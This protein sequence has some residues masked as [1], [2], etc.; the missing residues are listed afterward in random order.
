MEE[1][2]N[3][4]VIDDIDNIEVENINTAEDSSVKLP[5]G[6]ELSLSETYPVSAS[7]DTYYVLIAGGTASGKTTLLTLFYQLFLIGPRPKDL[8]FAGSRTLPAFVARAYN[9][10]I[11]SRRNEPSTPRTS[12]D[13]ENSILHL[14]FKDTSTEKISNL[15]ISDVS[16]EIF[17]HV[18]GNTHAAKEAFQFFNTVDQLVLLLDGEKLLEIKTRF[19]EIEQSIQLLQTFLGADIL[20]KGL[21][22]TV[23]ISKYDK[24]KEAN[25]EEILQR[26]KECFTDQLPSLQSKLQYMN[27]AAM[28]TN[29]EILPIGYGVQDMLLNILQNNAQNSNDI[30]VINQHMK[31]QVNLFGWRR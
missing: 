7:E 31:S 1:T 3:A 8:L 26:V 16:G 25:E 12:R 18:I 30:F 22:I 24:L 29:L 4:K 20:P 14:R 11:N 17:E 9:T 28:P 15:L 21:R 23:A 13:Q 5:T 6:R 27:I 10:W 2:S 19:A